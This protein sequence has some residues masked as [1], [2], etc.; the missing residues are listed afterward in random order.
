MPVFL[1]VAAIGVQSVRSSAQFASGINLVEVYVTVL[2][3]R[4]EP[5]TGLKASDFT[6]AEDGRGQV[7]QTFAAGDFPLSL[8]LGIDRSFS[9]ERRQLAATVRAVQQMLGELRDDDRVM[10][11]AIGS[12]VE[13]ITPLSN[14]RRAAYFAVEG[15]QPWGTT[16]LFDATMTAIEAIHGASG[17]RALVLITDGVD[18]Y[19]K[20][21]ADAV[22]EGAQRK[23]VLVYPVVTGRTHSMI[24]GEMAR[25]TGGRAVTVTSA[26][27]LPAALTSIA[28]ELRHQY[29]IGYAPSG[30]GGRSGWRSI[31]VTVKR[32]EWR[33][34][35]RDGYYADR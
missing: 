32:P 24:F 6:V 25:V 12:E 33:V 2:D 16:P 14:N 3:E 5:V 18:R 28:R 29:L 10:V 21:T 20:T 9:V 8:A 13:T 7:I 1:L 35:A 19:S 26:Q 23:D 17:R 27:A 22:I 15:L 34:R 30:E 31:G 11:L 4:G